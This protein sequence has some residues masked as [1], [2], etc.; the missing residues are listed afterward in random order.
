MRQLFGFVEYLDTRNA[1]SSAALYTI[2]QVVQGLKSEDVETMYSFFAMCVT[3]RTCFD[4][5]THMRR[6]L[7]PRL[8]LLS[9]QLGEPLIDR[10]CAVAEPAVLHMFAQASRILTIRVLWPLWVNST[11]IG[12]SYGLSC[13]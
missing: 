6:G 4:D 13:P 10:L 11:A 5:L 2:L 3:D 9:C 12:Q 1:T 8:H 7:E